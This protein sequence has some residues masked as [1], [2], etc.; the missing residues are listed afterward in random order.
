MDTI[1]RWSGV[2]RAGNFRTGAGRETET[3]VDL[4]E[5]LYLAGYRRARLTRAGAHVG[6]VGGASTSGR[7]WWGESA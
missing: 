4:A 5:R 3:P 7:T 6:A 2:D 1:V